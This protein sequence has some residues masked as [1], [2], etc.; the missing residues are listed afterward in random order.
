MWQNTLHI[1]FTILTTSKYTVQWDQVSGWCKSNCHFALLNFAIW[2]RNP[3][4]FRNVV[5]LYII[6]TCI[7]QFLF[8]FAKDLSLA[9]YF[10]FTLDY[11]ND[12][13]QKANLSDFLSS[14]WV[15]K[16]QRQ[17]M[18]S[19]TQVTQEFSKDI[20]CSGGS[21]SLA[22]ETRVLKI[23][24]TVAG[25]WKLTMTNW[26][27]HQSWCSYN[28]MRSCQKTQC[29]PFYGLS[30][31]EA[32][33]KGEEVQQMDAS[34]T[35]NCHFEVSSSLILHNNKPF[36]GSFLTCHEKWILY[37][38]RRW[39]AQWLNWEEAS[40]SAK[41]LSHLWLFETPWTVAHQASLSI[42]NFRSLLKL[43]SISSTVVPFSSSLQS[44]PE[45]GSFP[46]SQFFALNGQSFGVSASA[47]VLPTNIQGWFP[48]GLIGWISL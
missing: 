41:S 9:V 18:T 5:M 31:L 40:S 28:N 3:F 48:L 30:A 29:W 44:L 23:R 43:M 12:V 33:W 8:F 17:L 10:I 22:E 27:N 15:I 42:T 24:N 35:E 38:N 4:F 20:Q 16:Q 26:E 19:T 46:M 47:S 25:H 32:N 45:S 2:L 1:K 37:D 13:R 7:S 11:R 39:P 21:G 34:W 14:K 36:L 6:L